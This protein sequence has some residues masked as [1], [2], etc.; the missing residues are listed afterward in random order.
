SR[1][2][3]EIGISDGVVVSEV[4]PKGAGARAGLQVGDVIVQI[5]FDRVKSIKDFHRLELSLRQGKPVAVRI[6]RNGQ[7]RF[8][9]VL[10]KP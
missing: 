6:V 3:A 8:V 9:S 2:L 7:S 4:S 1:Q 10:V 5:G